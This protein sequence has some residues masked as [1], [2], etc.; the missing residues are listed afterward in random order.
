MTNQDLTDNYPTGYNTDGGAAASSAAER[1]CTSLDGEETTGKT[2]AG[3]SYRAFLSSGMMGDMRFAEQIYTEWDRQVNKNRL[4][5][6]LKCKSFAWFMLHKETHLVRVAASAC[7]LRWCPLCIR[8]RKYI[9]TQSVANWLKD[10]TK[11]KFLTFTLKHHT[12]PLASQIDALYKYFRAIRKHPFFKQHIKGGI[13]FFQIKKSKDEKYWHP[14]IHVC[15]EGKYIPQKELA[16]LWQK[17][18]HGSYIVDIRG[19]KNIRKAADYVARYAAAPCR[20]F[21]HTPEDALEIV[22][23][24]HGRRICGTFGTAKGI[25]LRPTKCED[26]DDWQEI[27]SYWDIRNSLEFDD[28]AKGIWEAWTHNRPYEGPLPSPPPTIDE[29]F[30]A[31]ME[32]PSSFDQTFFTFWG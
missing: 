22:T 8:S 26:A 25:S 30:K 4:S 15:C 1:S 27:S 6:L 5:Q 10:K 23:S 3:S 14:H 9:I 19:V 7:G 11:P 18:T 28:I 21:G 32:R 12:A 16:A 31:E 24:L 2:E 17:I 29:A 20:L 13:W